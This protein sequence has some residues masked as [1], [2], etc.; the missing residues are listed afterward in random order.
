MRLRE[1]AQV[2]WRLRRFLKS[3]AMA[4]SRQTK[5]VPD[6]ESL[7]KDALLSAQ[8]GDQNQEAV[9]R[10][11]ISEVERYSAGSGSC[12]SHEF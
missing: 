4:Y 3:R 1:V 5:S 8:Y 7:I 6:C 10:E 12:L 2:G 9:L 11:F